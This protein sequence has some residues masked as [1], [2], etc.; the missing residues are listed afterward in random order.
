MRELRRERFGGHQQNDAADIKLQAE[1]KAGEWVAH[2]LPPQG[3]RKRSHDGSVS[4]HDIGINHNQSPRWQT[5]AALPPCFLSPCRYVSGEV[6]IPLLFI[7]S[8]LVLTA[9]PGRGNGRWPLS[10][11]HG[12]KL[13]RQDADKHTRARGWVVPRA[14]VNRGGRWLVLHRPLHPPRQLSP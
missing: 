10:P 14:C 5:L 12:L 6:S 8:F 2:T 7:P 11:T 4:L 1:R 13:E 9:I 3:G